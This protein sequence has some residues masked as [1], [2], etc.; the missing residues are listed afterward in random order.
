MNR[1]YTIRGVVQVS[2][3]LVHCVKEA[4]FTQTVG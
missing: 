3:Q 2:E 1:L 4:Q